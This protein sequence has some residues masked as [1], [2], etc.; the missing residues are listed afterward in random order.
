MGILIKNRV[1]QYME[2]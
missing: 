2:Y 1:V